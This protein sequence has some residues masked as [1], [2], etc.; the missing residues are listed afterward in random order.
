MTRLLKFCYLTFFYALFKLLPINRKVI[1][2]SSFY[3]RQYAG[4]P[5][6]IFE[7]LIAVRGVELKYVWVLGSMNSV[8]SAIRRQCTI[9]RR[10][11][12]RHV[13]FLAVAQY[14]IDNC[15]ESYLLR[16]KEGV[17][18][19]QTWHGTPIKKIAQD[20]PAPIYD[21]IKI[22][23]LRD[24]NSWTFLLAPSYFVANMLASSFNIDRKKVLPIGQ[25]RNDALTSRFSKE[26]SIFK[27]KVFGDR[28]CDRLVVMYAPTFRDDDTS[29]QHVPFSLEQF[30]AKFSEKYVLLL[31]FH[32][33]IITIGPTRTGD[34]DII[35][36]SE[37]DDLQSLLRI[38]D[39]LV[40]DYSSIV[41]DFMIL[42]RPIIYYPYDFEH[43]S[44]LLRGLY[45]SFEDLPGQVVHSEDDF[46]RALSD[47]NDLSD[48]VSP[49]KNKIFNEC[50]K[51]NS[52][53]AVLSHI[54]LIDD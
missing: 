31:R 13:Y 30:S 50:Q 19:V 32:S 48:N 36:V 34:N 12:L 6:A 41:F 39:V 7:T 11:S 8:P 15:Q 23:W 44:N 27:K 25:P 17:V 10:Y 37:V 5:R 24:S 54:G 18:Y 1:L 52:S 20:I 4:D 40:S 2:F 16:P 26:D 33:N 46:F 42:N 47:F 22:D 21:R 14:R 53:R 35:N 28:D 51:N 38:T 43:Y 3:G 9:V 29:K 49:E 45:F